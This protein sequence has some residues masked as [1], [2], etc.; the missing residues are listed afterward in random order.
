MSMKA[1]RNLTILSAVVVIAVF[2]A[3]SVDSIKQVSARTPAITGQVTAGKQAW[4]NHDCI[5]CHTILGNGAYFAP[6]LTKVY[7]QKGEKYLTEFLTNPVVE[8]SSVK[9][10]KEEVANLVAFFKWVD[11]VDTNGWPPK[12]LAQSAGGSQGETLFAQN[13]NACHA[14]NGK[15]GNTGP[16]LGKIGSRM[17]AKSIQQKITS[18]GPGSKMPPF[19][20]ISQADVTALSEYLA[21]LK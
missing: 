19:S 8:M 20:S 5:G 6:D 13:C 1:V 7:N 2:L 4:Q 16:D 21:G 10:S 17:G 9:L 12:P 14:I 3:L 18:P 11:G 15:G